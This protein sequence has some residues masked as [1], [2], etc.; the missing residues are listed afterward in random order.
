LRILAHNVIHQTEELLDTLVETKI[1]T[2]LF[3]SGTTKRYMKSIRTRS[4][5]GMVHSTVLPTAQAYLD[6]EEV[7]LFITSEDTDTLGFA[8]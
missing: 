4:D 6:K 5:W 2:A 1:F 8:D 7:I 3:T